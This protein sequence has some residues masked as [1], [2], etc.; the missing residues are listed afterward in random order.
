MRRTSAARSVAGTRLQDANA[1]VATSTARPASAIVPSGKRPM[2]CWK[3]LGLSD[4]N[5]FEA[6]T[7]LPPMTLRPRIG[8]RFSTLER[9][10]RKALRF[11]STEKSVKG[12]LVNS[13][14]NVTSGGG[15]LSKPRT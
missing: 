3:S 13:G 9:A 7:I 10:A 5:C 14:S 8:S 4:S 11:A 2:T 15:N 12:S 6:G 1:F